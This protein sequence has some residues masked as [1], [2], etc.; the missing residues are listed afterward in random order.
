MTFLR[1]FFTF[2]PRRSRS[3]TGSVWPAASSSPGPPAPPGSPCPSSSWATSTRCWPTASRSWQ[4]S[5]RSRAWTASSSWTCRPRP[6]MTSSGAVPS[7]T[8]QS[9]SR[10]LSEWSKCPLPAGPAALAPV[11]SVFVRP[12]PAPPLFW[13]LFWLR[14]ATI[15]DLPGRL[16]GVLVWLAGT[17]CDLSHPPAPR[18]WC[19]FIC[20]IS[21]GAP[22]DLAGI[23][24]RTS[25]PSS[26]SLLL[27]TATSTAFWTMFL[28]A[29]L[30]VTPPHA[31]RVLCYTQYPWRLCADWC[32]RSNVVS[33]LGL[34]DRRGP[35]RQPG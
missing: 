16:F 29:F 24:T 3:R 31:R 19:S 5:R 28:R 9:Q 34:Q 10:Q 33:K 15:C 18:W 32:L 8:S 6:P 17:T 23:L 26:P 25:S 11:F 20:S 7:G 4:R 35:D 2:R 30:S 14:S 27:R 12:L 22:H 21:R 13:F 1:P